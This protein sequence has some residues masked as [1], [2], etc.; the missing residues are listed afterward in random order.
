M[1]FSLVKLAH[2]YEIPSPTPQFGNLGDVVSKI[3]PAAITLAGLLTFLYLILGGFKYMTAGGDEKAVTAAKTMITN[4][5]IG[6]IIV[7]AA[8]WIMWILE[9]VLGLDIL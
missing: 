9:T 1:K 7:F 8:Y 2:A 3:V 6:L 5:V 4:A